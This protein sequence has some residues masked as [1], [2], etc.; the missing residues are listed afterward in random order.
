[1]PAFPALNHVA[2]TVRD[3]S[4]QHAVVPRAVRQPTRRST[5][6]PT[7]A[8]ATWC[9]RWATARCSGSTSTRRPRRTRNSASS[10]P[11][12]TTSRS[13]A[14][15]GRV[16]V[17]GDRLDELGVSTAASSTRTTARG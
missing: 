14:R 9:G 11:G 12:S 10:G 15:R 3:L 16:G 8:S 1:M 17:V 5:R 6:T 7:P 2:V 4:R 13:A